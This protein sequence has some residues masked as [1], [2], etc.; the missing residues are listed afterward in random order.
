[1]FE[2]KILNFAW[3]N[4]LLGG[5]ISRKQTKTKIFFINSEF[6][7]VSYFCFGVFLDM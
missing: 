2:Y 3:S 6:E 5:K 4:V 7:D 1:M